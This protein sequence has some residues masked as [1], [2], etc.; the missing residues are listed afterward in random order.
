MALCSIAIA[1]G[2]IGVVALVKGLVFRRRFGFGR[3]GGG[4][5]ALASC[6]PSFGGGGCGGGGGGGGGD[7][8][9]G[10]GRRGGFGGGF[11]GGPGGSFWLRALFSRLDTTPGQ[12]K[13][14]RS[15]IEDFQRTAREAKE[16]LKSARENLANAIKGEEVDE[17]ALGEANN[18]ADA[19]ATQIKDALTN[20]LKRV[21]ATLDA[22]Q[23]GRLAD[24]L[25]KGPGFGR[26]GWGN[27]YRD[28]SL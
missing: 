21:H 28:A 19:T 10:W 3:G 8:Y 22:N 26:R 27:P 18:R 23:R 6:G 2:V 12:E 20:A 16:G 14:I 9:S 7:H 15:A 17:V 1:A 4:P 11:G 24:L 5:W 13:E 25:A